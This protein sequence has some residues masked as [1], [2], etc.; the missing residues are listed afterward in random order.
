[1]AT[2]KLS[3]LDGLA[4]TAA[5]LGYNDLSVQQ[6][7]KGSGLTGAGFVYK[8]S[9]V[10]EGALIFTRLF[11]DLTDLTSGGA[12]NDIVGG[13]GG[14][15]NSHFGQITAALNGTIVA[16]FIDV[17]ETP[18]GGG[19]DIDLYGSTDAT[20]A[21]D[22]DATAL[23]GTG[24]LCNAGAWTAGNRKILSAFPAANEYLYLA[25]VAGTNA[26][27]TAGQFLLTLVGT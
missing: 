19:T 16:G 15:A 22:A 27:F 5:E 17:I 13:T 20:G 24:S 1:M 21:E 3:L 8:S 23:A 14:A 6:L 4:V 7:T 11:V 10:R 12:A 25:E 9:V 2:I 18:A 26:A